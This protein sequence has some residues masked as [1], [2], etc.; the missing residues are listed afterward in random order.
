MLDINADRLLADLYDLRK[1]GAFK[2]GVHRPTL[3]PDDVLSRHWLVERLTAFG[4]D[5]EIDGIANVIG[6]APGKGPHILAGS[7]IETQ[8]E[9]G[10]LDGAL[11]VIYALEAARAVAESGAYGEHGVDVIAFADEEG[12]FAD[13]PGSQ[14]WVGT[15][16]EETIDRAVDRS[17][18]TPLREALAKAGLHGRPR[19]RMERDRYLCFLEAHIEQGGWLEANDLTIGVVTSIVGSWQYRILIKGQQNHAGTTMMKM[20]RDAGVAA[21]RLL[22]AIE[23]EFPKIAAELTVW[24]AGRITLD[25]GAPAIV[26]G[27]A[28]ILFQFRDADSAVLDRLH[29]KLEELVKAEDATGPCDVGLEVVSIT[30]PA[31]MDGS[32]RAAFTEAAERICPD[33]HKLMPSGAGHDARTLAPHIPSGMLFVPSINGVSHH[34][35]ENTSDADIVAGARVFAGAVGD[36]L[37]AAR[38]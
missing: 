5:A 38:G 33:R 4:H 6:R 15:L 17:H 1:I 19:R 32:L 12:H 37:A 14:S 26:P 23:T 35:S 11:G 25:P 36:L 18:G 21:T 31:L 29:A 27:G 30:H 8:N 22:Q 16:S 28:E 2:T 9:A 3:S 24:T 34:W 13:M 20:R 10:W 7:H